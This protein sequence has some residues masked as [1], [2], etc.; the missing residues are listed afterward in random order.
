MLPSCSRGVTPPF[1]HFTEHT[2]ASQGPTRPAWTTR[3]AQRWWSGVGRCQPAAVP[4]QTRQSTQMSTHQHKRC[5][6]IHQRRG[7][8]WQYIEWG[9]KSTQCGSASGTAWCF[10]VPAT[11]EKKNIK[12][13]SNWLALTYV[14]K[15][16]INRDSARLKIS[17]VREKMQ[18]LSPPCWRL[19]KYTWLSAARASLGTPR[20][21]F[22]HPW[23]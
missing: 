21:H 3:L 23:K 1:R 10:L 7:R 16:K 6:T 19:I 20:H 11:K 22:V 18:P 5:V 15:I 9:K 13:K 2:Q 12:Q 8:R 14:K 4:P 17:Q